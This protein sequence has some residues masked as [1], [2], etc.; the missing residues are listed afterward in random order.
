MKEQHNKRICKIYQQNVQ[1][2]K[3]L[4][5]IDSL[6]INKKVCPFPSSNVQDCKSCYYKRWLVV[7][8]KMSTYEALPGR[9]TIE[10]I[11]IN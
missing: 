5:N 8:Q 4:Y 3:L 10:T 7:T 9:H 2:T 11:I 1:N 6:Y